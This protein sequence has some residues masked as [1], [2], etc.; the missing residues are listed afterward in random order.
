MT[1]LAAIDIG[2]NAIRL[3]I[4]DVNNVRESYC[5]GNESPE[6]Y[7]NRVAIR[8]GDDVYTSGFISIET[9]S[10]ALKSP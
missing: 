4:K 2:S 9:S 1:K 5:P 6:D 8:L 3:Y 7:F 10:I